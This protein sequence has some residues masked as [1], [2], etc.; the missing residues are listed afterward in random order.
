[1]ADRNYAELINLAAEMARCISMPSPFVDDEFFC[2]STPLADRRR[3]R[4]MATLAE[5]QA[6][7]WAVRVRAI[8]DR[9]SKQHGA[10]HA[11]KG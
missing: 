3:Y 6:K 4:E 2:R 9:L 11:D 8:A 1:M 10:G 7:E 5:W